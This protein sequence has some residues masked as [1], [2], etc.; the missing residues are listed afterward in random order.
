MSVFWKTLIHV[1]EEQE[2]LIAP[3]AIC[4]DLP[5]VYIANAI[6]PGRD[7]MILILLNINYI[8]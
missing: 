6:S 7:C 3:Y 2:L 1:G 5:L 4:S 8:L